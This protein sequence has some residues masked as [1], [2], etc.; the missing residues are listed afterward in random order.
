MTRRL[1]RA[2]PLW[3]RLQAHQ[4]ARKP[5]R[6]PS[7][8]ETTEG[9][10]TIRSR[11]AI[12]LEVDPTS[13]RI[14][15]FAAV[16][17]RAPSALVHSGGDLKAA[18][19]NLDDFC[20]G[21][22]FIVG[23]NILDFDLPQLAGA[24]PALALLQKAPIDTL[25]LNPLAFPRNPYHRLVKHYQDGRLVGGGRSNPELDARL[26][27]ELLDEQLAALSALNERT[28]DLALVFHW[29][30][31]KE[32]RSAG[33]DSVFRAFRG[34]SVPT[35]DEAR[36]C[37]ERCLDGE[38]CTTNAQEVI[39]GAGGL[40][41]P[42]AYAIS[43]ISVAGGDSVMPPWVRHRFPAAGRIVR[44]LRDTACG[45]PGCQW[46][47]Q[48]NDPHRLLA[49]WFGFDGFRPEPK[50]ADGSPLQEEIVARA[51]AG[52][53][54]LGILPTGTGKSVCFQLPALSKYEKTGA[55]TVVISPLVA[56]MADQVDGLRRHGR[57][58]VSR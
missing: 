49:R 51:L 57:A 13:N 35:G 28:P 42:L 20:S 29:L 36:D 41:W 39:R 14:F 56:L 32:Q 1:I 27:L 22:D 12:D 58:G 34:R 10:E 54:V 38:A 43:W 4:A 2:L 11:A 3:R 16:T 15:A 26:A 7:E 23:H 48:H 37:L 5:L 18:L 24:D 19:K 33:F 47:V 17:P 53:C 25:R 50:G 9:R 8:I 44:D 52:D 30:V 6:A 21:A 55:L 31:T 40:G 46:C 45:D